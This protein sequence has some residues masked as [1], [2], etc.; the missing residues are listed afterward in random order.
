MRVRR[1]NEWAALTT[2]DVIDA[3]R[4]VPSEPIQERVINIS[5][6]V[7][8]LEQVFATVTSRAPGSFTSKEARRILGRLGFV[9]RR[10]SRSEIS[11]PWEGS[12][13]RVQQGDDHKVYGDRLYSPDAGAA[14]VYSIDP[15]SLGGGF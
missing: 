9:C 14:A 10:A 4:G 1:K 3:M 6:R 11:A 13:T 7:Y 12:F 15:G 2:L 8:P 5:G